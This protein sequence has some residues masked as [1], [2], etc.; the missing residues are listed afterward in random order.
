MKNSI[1]R[2]I[3]KSKINIDYKFGKLYEINLIIDKEEKD[4]YS[5]KTPKKLNIN[6][7]Q[8]IENKESE[9][10]KSKIARDNTCKEISDLYNQNNIS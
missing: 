1:P 2:K 3:S 7:K 9:L 6:N 10:K 4:L 5:L 8:H